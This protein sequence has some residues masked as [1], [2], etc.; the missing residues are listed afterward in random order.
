MREGAA[1]YIIPSDNWEQQRIGCRTDWF[2]HYIIPSDN[3]EQQQ[4][5]RII[6]MVHYYIIPSDNWEQQLHTHHY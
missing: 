3:W 2:F 5:L 1:D 4:G 6:K